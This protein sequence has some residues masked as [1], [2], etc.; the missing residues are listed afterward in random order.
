MNFWLVKFRVLFFLIFKFVSYV[1]WSFHS[2]LNVTYS[3]ERPEANKV[4]KVSSRA[5]LFDR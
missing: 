4:N 2:Q 5:L 3:T 1:T